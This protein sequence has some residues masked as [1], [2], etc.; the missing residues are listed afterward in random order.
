[1][2][3][4]T[5]ANSGEAPDGVGHPR[6]RID[7]LPGPRPHSFPPALGGPSPT[8]DAPPERTP[9]AEVAVSPDSVFVTVELPGAPKDAMDIQATDSAL[10][11]IAPRVGAAGYRLAIDLPVRVVPDSARA[12]YRN[13]ILDVTLKRVNS[14]GG[15]SREV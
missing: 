5:D 2:N 14:S 6:R 8:V 4:D 3:H 7:S 15:E 12:T 9:A 10:S 13:G 11:V 1:M